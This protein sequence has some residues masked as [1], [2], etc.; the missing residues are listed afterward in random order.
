MAN[1]ITSDAFKYLR[2]LPDSPL[3]SKLAIKF[4]NPAEIPISDTAAIIKTKLLMAENTPKSDIDIPLA[5]RTVNKNAK[6]AVN[7]FPTKRT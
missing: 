6:K 4:T 2:A 3:D 7:K 5:T 1:L